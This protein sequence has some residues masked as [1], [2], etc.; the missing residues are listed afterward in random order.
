MLIGNRVELMPRLPEEQAL[1]RIYNTECGRDVDAGPLGVA[2]NEA[3]GAYVSERE[4]RS[5]PEFDIDSSSISTDCIVQV[6]FHHHAEYP[7]HQRNPTSTAILAAAN[8][9]FIST[10]LQIH[11]VP[12]GGV[13]FITA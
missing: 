2:V 5:G 1:T 12:I 6:A 8:A 4:A 11:S 13:C 10:T 3:A 9:S 7:P